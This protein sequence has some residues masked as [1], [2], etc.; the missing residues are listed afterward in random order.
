VHKSC[1][2]IGLILIVLTLP[3]F[4]ATVMRD[5]NN[6]TSI[7]TGGDLAV[8]LIVDVN[9]SENYY[10][11]EE[12][13]PSNWI[14][15]DTGTGSLG[16]DKRIRWAV[17]DNAIDINYNYILKAPTRGEIATFYG[18]YM[19]E[20]MPLSKEIEGQKYVIVNESVVLEDSQAKLTVTPHTAYSPVGKYKQMFEVCNKTGTDTTIFGAFVFNFDLNS[21]SVRYWRKPVF[22]WVSHQFVCDYN[23]VYKLNL[24]PTDQNPHW[25]KCYHNVTDVNGYDENTV[26][27][28]G[29]FKTGNL[30]SKTIN[31]DVNELVSGNNWFDVTQKFTED[32]FTH[33]GKQ[34]YPYL[35]GLLVKA[36]SCEKWEI[37][38]VPSINDNTKKWEAWLWAGGSWN[39]ILTDTCTKTLKLDPWWGTSGWSYRKKITLATS[40]YLSGNITNDHVIYVKQTA[41]DTDFWNHVQSDGRDVR[42]AAADGSTELKFYFQRFDNA[43][44][45]MDAWVKVTDI[46]TSD[47]NIDIYMYYGNAGASDAQ[48]AANTLT[49]YLAVYHS[50]EGTGTAV[51][52]KKGAYNATASNSAIWD[53]TTQKIGAAGLN[54][55]TAYYAYQDT[56]LDTPPANLSIGFWFNPTGAT[57]NYILDKWNTSGE[58][59]YL[60]ITTAA[61]NTKIHVDA[62]GGGITSSLTTTTTM[63]SGTWYH[64]ILAWST[65]L[66]L[67]LYLNGAWEAGNAAATSLMGAVSYYDFTIGAYHTGNYICDGKIDEVKVMNVGIDTNEA[68]LLYRSEN[69]DLQTY[70]VEEGGNTTPYMASIDLNATYAKQNDDIKVTASGAGDADS[71][72]ITLLCGTSPN[73]SI[74]TNNFCT[75]F[76]N[77]S[78][79]SDVSC[80]GK[81]ASGDGTK[82]I[83]CRMWD[84]IAYSIDQNTDTYTADNTA[85][86]VSS[87]VMNYS[88]ALEGIDYDLNMTITESGSGLATTTYKCWSLNSSEE[89]CTSASWDCKT[90]NLID[91]G[92][93]NYGAGI[94]GS[95]KDTNETWTCKAY[96]TDNVGLQ[97]TGTDTETMNETTGIT[98]DSSSIIYGG[99]KGSTCNAATTDQTNPYVLIT[100]NGNIDLNILNL[101]GDLNYLSYTLPKINHKWYLSNNCGSATSCTGENQELNSLW[102]KGTYPT[103]ATMNEYYWLDIPVAQQIGN[104][105][106]T[107]TIGATKSGE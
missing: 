38:Y 101:C 32:K 15:K 19:A 33:N 78:P 100:H 84:G 72:N 85:P 57:S 58:T 56:L 31:Y 66:G 20:G 42:F 3:I 39:C 36:N 70:G 61:S 14:V 86:V 68:M 97:G 107:I 80:V 90:G 29:K 22:S 48:D 95:I 73:P 41:A 17:I 88:N 47:S 50:D 87:V 35:D 75:D 40:N 76:G 26:Y 25:A 62:K 69:G 106:G 44:D 79:Y 65:S 55:A 98:I 30:P 12:T 74:D 67:N 54:P 1:L 10:A 21:G 77:A 34:V 96:A 83:Y 27:F 37:N 93:N 46:F 51:N 53:T 16:I 91:N 102:G 18:E 7:L 103:A 71:D 81:G 28:E 82:T 60:Q 9:N 104:Y 11:I 89:S 13:P 6:S 2:A 52:D 105:T 94:T 49:N 59:D 24:Y 5:F 43:N 99:V 64:G 8:K 4:A 63:S 92:S 23:F 45:L